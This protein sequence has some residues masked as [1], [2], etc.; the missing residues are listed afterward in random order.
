MGKYLE[1]Y[2]KENMRTAM[3]RQEETFTHQ[4]HELH[5]LYRV[6]KVLLNDMKAEIEKQRKP[7]NSGTRIERWNADNN[8]MTS[9]QPCYSTC[10]DQ[11][12]FGRAL[13]LD[14]PAEE[15]IRKDD[16]EVDEYSDLELTLA[17]GSKSRRK[18][19]NSFTSDSRA[20]FSSSSSESGATRTKLNGNDWGLF[21]VPDVNRGSYQ[22]ERKRV[23]Q[24]PWLFHRP[25]LNMT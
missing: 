1:Q 11:T 15:Y 19:E 16:R 8:E 25:S 13:D 9:Q 23:A 22:K 7:S 6:Q 5:R 17:T 4:V 10:Q 12:R 20:S 2:E 3:L 18:E 21:Q 14:L 24:P